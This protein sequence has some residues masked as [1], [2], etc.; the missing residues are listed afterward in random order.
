MGQ[1]AQ[2][3]N[4][5]WRWG[6][7]WGTFKP[8]RS[9]SLNASYIQLLLAPEVSLSTAIIPLSQLKILLRKVS[10]FSP[11]E[12][13]DQGPLPYHFLSLS[14]PVTCSS[15]QGRE[16][17]VSCLTAHR[18]VLFPPQ[19][20]PALGGAMPCASVT[21]G[22]LFSLV[23]KVSINSPAGMLSGSWKLVGTL[24]LS[25]ALGTVGLKDRS[26]N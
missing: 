19:A 10:L 22:Q 9:G 4:H 8:V 26:C 13:R 20:V 14:I 16:L 6:S 11:A 12:G 23:E 7:K 5:F 21:W 2:L 1:V 17:R 15:Q 25:K 18:P 3:G 24:G